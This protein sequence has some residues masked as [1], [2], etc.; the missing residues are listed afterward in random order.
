VVNGLL[1][2]IHERG[3]SHYELVESFVDGRLLGRALEHAARAGYFQH[4]F[5]DT[6][7]VLPGR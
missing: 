4:E 3:T 6:V 1:T 2:G 7:L 5:G